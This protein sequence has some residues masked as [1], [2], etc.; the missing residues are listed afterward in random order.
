MNRVLTRLAMLYIVDDNNDYRFLLGRVFNRFLP[1][2]APRFFADGDE[3]R[4]LVLAGGER[5]QVVL[6]DL[7]MPI[8][9]GY[10]TLLFLRGQPDWRY[11]PVVVMTSSTAGDEKTTC[12]K[13]GA[14]SF[15]PKP[16]GLD[17][18]KRVM[19]TVCTYWLTYNQAPN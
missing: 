15:M 8:L 7:D 3:L 13:A 17:D 19:E 5:P 11:V 16:N 1:Q 10:D 18:M 12:Y 9:N 14:T 2:Y 6:L 4:Q